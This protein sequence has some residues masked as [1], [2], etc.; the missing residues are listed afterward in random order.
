[1]DLDETWQVGLRLE[2]TKPCAFP[3]KSRDGFRRERE[4]IGRRPVVFLWR[5]RR[6]TSATFLRSISA[7]LSMKTCPGGGWRHVVSCSRK[8]ATKRSNFP[9]NRLF[10]AQK[11]T[12]FVMRLPG[13]G[14]RSAT[15]KLFPSPSGHPIDLRF[16]GDFCWG[17]YRFPAVH[18][19]P[20]REWLYY[21]RYWSSPCL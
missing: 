6:T 9:K 21:P 19:R 5:V 10:S 1:M 12:L 3:A 13:H 20:I 4:K 15:P 8:V 11:G 18:V 7:K 2:N 16:L 14:K 17:M